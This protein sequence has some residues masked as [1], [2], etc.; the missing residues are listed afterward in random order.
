MKNKTSYDDFIKYGYCISKLSKYRFNSERESHRQRR[1][2]V[3]PL[4][5][6][7]IYFHFLLRAYYLIT[8]DNL[9][10]K[11]RDYKSMKLR[12]KC[13]DWRTKKRKKIGLGN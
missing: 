8:D 5:M 4:D 11:V 13:I 3:I 6:N 2:P 12:T 7:P 1:N 10:K 9:E